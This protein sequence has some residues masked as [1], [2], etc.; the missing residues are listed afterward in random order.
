MSQPLS[1]NT[2]QEHVVCDVCARTLLRGEQMETFVGSGRRSNVCELCKPHALNEGWMREG[3]IPE[4]QGGG[5]RVQRRRSL[6]RRR[7][8][9]DGADERGD[10]IRRGVRPLV[11]V[12]ANRATCTRSRQTATT[13]SPPP[14]MCST[15]AST[16]AR[17][18]AWP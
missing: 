10:E 3:A 5:D 12:L 16:A 11:P 4:Y 8:G 13:R 17:W 15:T 1:I 6:L 2:T 18:P 7:W 9:K 14:S